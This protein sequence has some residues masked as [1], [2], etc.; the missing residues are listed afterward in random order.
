MES[1]HRSAFTDPPIDEYSAAH[2]TGPDR[3][4]VELQEITREK[5]GDAR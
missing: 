4:Q 2:S 3:H 1:R 5:T